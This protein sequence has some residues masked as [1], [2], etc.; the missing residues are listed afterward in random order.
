VSVEDERGLI[1]EMTP[2]DVEEQRLFA[3]VHGRLFG[4]SE[5]VLV[6]RYTLERRLGAGTMGEVYLARDSGLDRAVALKLIHS[7]LARGRPAERLRREARA[8]ARLAHPNVVHVYEVDQHQG[9][10]F[11]AMEYI[12]GS[13]LRAWI[14]ERRPSWSEVR[15]AYVEAGR[16]LAAAH[17][18][19]LVH[20]DFKPL[21]R[22]PC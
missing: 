21:S 12:R 2:G 20:R 18:V 16:G 22:F 3:S 8:L 13:S 17:T 1:A 19:G 4:H 15:D 5:P 6:G 11:L 9:R 14:A 10:V 7:H